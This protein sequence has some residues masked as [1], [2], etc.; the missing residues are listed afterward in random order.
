MR[1][2]RRME[3]AA[4]EIVTKGTCAF[5]DVIL[6]GSGRGMEIWCGMVDV[7]REWQEDRDETPL[8]EAWLLEQGF[9]FHRKSDSYVLRDRRMSVSVRLN[10][11]LWLSF[12]ASYSGSF[13]TYK[14][15]TTRG[16]IRRLCREVGIETLGQPSTRPKFT[17]DQKRKAHELMLE[18]GD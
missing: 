15:F 12:D 17:R 2:T 6:G 11:Q 18:I 16:Q 3:F 1:D 4:G 8:D 9:Y 10:G 5:P 13:S 14:K 7:L